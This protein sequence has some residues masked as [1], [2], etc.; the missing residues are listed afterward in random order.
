[1]SLTELLRDES[2]FGRR[3]RPSAR[4][5]VLQFESTVGVSRAQTRRSRVGRRRSNLRPTHRRIRIGGRHEA[6][7]RGR[8]LN[9]LPSSGQVETTAPRPAAARAAPATTSSGP[10]PALTR[11]AILLPQYEAGV[12]QDESDRDNDNRGVT[13][14]PESHVVGEHHPHNVFDVAGLGGVVS[15]LLN[16]AQSGCR[17]RT[18][19]RRASPEPSA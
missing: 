5:Q 15:N 13:L 14:G 16:P 7:N 1:M 9:L 3:D 18:T 8:A 6:S 11:V 17:L 2:A 10:G 19:L 12:R 4:R